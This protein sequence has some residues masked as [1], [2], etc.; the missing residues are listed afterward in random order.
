MNTEEIRHLLSTY[1]DGKASAAE[2]GELKRYFT[3][4]REVPDDLKA[5]ACMFRA[6]AAYKAPAVPDDLKQR[7]VS[8]TTGRRRNIFRLLRPALAAAASVALIVSLSFMFMRN[9]GAD[10]AEEAP[11]LAWTE[12]TEPVPAPQMPE[13]VT[14]TEP[15][16]TPPAKTVHRAVS[17]PRYREITD[18]AEVVEMTVRLLAKVDATLAKM[19]DNVQL[20]AT[21]LAMV[22]NPLRANEIQKDR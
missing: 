19:E 14:K 13:A 3:A 6:M 21:A 4:N 9:N 7:I 11:Q 1:Y 10:P 12:I 22:S 20:T 16:T 15:V 17:R 2:I 8:A 18:S 5:D